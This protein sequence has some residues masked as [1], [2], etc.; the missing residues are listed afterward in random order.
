MLIGEYR[1]TLDPKKR[2]ALPAKVRRD[3]GEV[4]VLTRGLDTCLSV[5]PKE[6]WEKVVTKLS[7][8]PQGQAG[9][10]S[11]VR[12]MLAGAVEVELDDLG[13]V[14]VPDYL[15][16]YAG[17]QKDVVVVGV[18]NR[19]EIWD[20]TKWESYQSAAERSTESVA[21]KLGELGAY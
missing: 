2:L 16:E 14:L 4:V 20:R 21:E 12:L 17:L 15:K 3:L 11:F 19:L 8:L 6:E 13:R 5:Y 9:T 18:H 1:H 7:Q 10:R